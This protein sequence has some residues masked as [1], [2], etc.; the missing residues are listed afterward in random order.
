ML[1]KTNTYQRSYRTQRCP[2]EKRSF[3][4]VVYIEEPAKYSIIES[5]RLIDVD[6]RGYG[7]IKEL[8]KSYGVHVEQTGILFLLYVNKL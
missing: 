7:T 3:S 1:S 5:K 8:G 2:Q 4:C 6:E